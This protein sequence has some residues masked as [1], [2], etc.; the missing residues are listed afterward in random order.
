M[1]PKS[2]VTFIL[3]AF[4]MLMVLWVL[5]AYKSFGGIV[6]LLIG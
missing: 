3:G 6:P 1:K 2:M 5:V 4:P